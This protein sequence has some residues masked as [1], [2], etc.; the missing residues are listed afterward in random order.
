GNEPARHLCPLL[1]GVGSGPGVM[2]P[3]LVVPLIVVVVQQGL[4]GGE[5]LEGAHAIADCLLVGA[6][7]LTE[8]TPRE[9]ITAAPHAEGMLES[10][11]PVEFGRF[12]VVVFLFVAN[13]S[14]ASFPSLDSVRA[15]GSPAAGLG[16][17]APCAEKV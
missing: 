6:F 7:G 15:C 2:H 12:R 17:S 16:G 4:H 3:G 11:I 8:L 14:S 1:D 5:S 9:V 13:H 10:L